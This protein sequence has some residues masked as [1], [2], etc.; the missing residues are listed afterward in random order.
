[1]YGFRI[2]FLASVFVDAESITATAENVTGLLQALQDKA[3][4][5][6][7][8]Q[9]MSSTSP[10]PLSRIGFATSDGG[11]QFTLLGKRFDFARVAT[12]PDGSNIGDFAMFCQEAIPKLTTALNYFQRRAH[13]LAAVQEG[14]LPDMAKTEMDNVAERLFSFPPVYAANRPFEWDWR[15]ASL[16]ERSFGGLKEL[17]NTLTTIKRF[18]G[19]ILKRDGEQMTELSIDR[20]RVDFDINTLPTNI[21]ARFDDFHLADFFKQSISWHDKLSTKIFPYI[22][23]GKTNG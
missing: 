5:P 10:V 18:A 14:F 20:I 15:M 1:M 22:L 8:V 4:I 13:R 9:E 6:V 3:F 12:V 16:V 21:I 17:T 7:N 19:V 11:C 2:R 23:G